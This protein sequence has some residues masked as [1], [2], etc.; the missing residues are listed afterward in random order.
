[1]GESL[2]QRRRVGDN[3]EKSGLI[4]RK[5]MWVRLYEERLRPLR[6]ELAAYQ[7]VGG[8]MAHQAED[9]VTDVRA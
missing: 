7:V 5:F 8:V 9:G 3:P 6:E 2:T 1:M 4:P